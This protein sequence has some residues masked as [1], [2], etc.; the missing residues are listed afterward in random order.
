VAF[1]SANFRL[2]G[3]G[4]GAVLLRGYVAELPSLV[5]AIAAGH[6]SLATVTAPPCDVEAVWTAQRKDGRRVVL[7]PA[8]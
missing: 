1:R 2:Q 6:L 3:V 5:E 7:V 8:G 4:Q